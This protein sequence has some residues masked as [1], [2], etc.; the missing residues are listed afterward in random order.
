MPPH[1][2]SLDG[3]VV[4][5]AKAALTEDN[6]ELILPFVPE[7]A[8]DQVRAAFD[9]TRAAQAEGGHFTHE[10][11]DLYFFDTVVRLHRAGEGAPFTGLKPAGLDVGPVIP[12][13][14]EA[15][16]TQSIDKL[17]EFLSAEL[18]RQLQTRLDRLTALTGGVTTAERRAY[19]EATLGLQV[20]SHHLYTMMRGDQH[21][22]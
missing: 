9:R 22:D 8:E 12:L 10:V 13:A 14:E 21:G 6:A 3:P 19:V 16:D 18:R 11:A 7:S 2:D 5:A 20:Y 1:C 17:Y 15:I 4:T